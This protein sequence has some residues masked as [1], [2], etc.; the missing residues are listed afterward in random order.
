MWD[1]Q[2]SRS[3]IIVRRDWGIWAIAHIVLRGL[4]VTPP[5]DVLVWFLGG[6]AILHRNFPVAFHRRSSQSIG[7]RA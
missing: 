2:E 1:S 4:A 3:A 7:C 6:D 5:D